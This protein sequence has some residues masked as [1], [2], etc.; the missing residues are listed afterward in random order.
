M[1]RERFVTGF[2]DPAFRFSMNFVGAPALTAAEFKDYRQDLILGASLRIIV[3][4]GQYD[5]TKLVNIGSNRWSLKPEIG[6]SKAFGPMDRRG[7]ARCYYLHEQWRF[8]RWSDTRTGA[9][10]LG[11]GEPDL[12]LRTQLLAGGECRLFRR[13]THN[14]RWREEQRSTGRA[15][16][17]RDLRAS[18]QSV[19]IGEVLCRHRLQRGSPP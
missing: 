15:S 1:P 6:C 5:D 19:S 12:H 2:G 17:W 16:F 4:L 8:L 18:R 11:A 10:L 13:W 14:G 9:N 7:C 3:P